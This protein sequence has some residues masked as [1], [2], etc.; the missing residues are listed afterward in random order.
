MQNFVQIIQM[1]IL[2]PQRLIYSN[3]T[4]TVKLNKIN[5]NNLFHKLS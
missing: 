5:T 2:I 3:Y 4:Y 1:A